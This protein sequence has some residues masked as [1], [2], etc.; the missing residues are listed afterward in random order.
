M[1]AQS[2]H[3][4]IF[5]PTDLWLDV[6]YCYDSFLCLFPRSVKGFVKVLRIIHE[7]SSMYLEFCPLRTDFGCYN[8]LFSCGS[9]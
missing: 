4:D 1:L 3:M 5:E 6:I 9:A 2:K 7:Q 8:A